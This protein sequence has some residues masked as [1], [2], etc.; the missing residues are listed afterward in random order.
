MIN[1]IYFDALDDEGVSDLFVYKGDMPADDFCRMQKQLSSK[2]EHRIRT[3]IFAAIA[4]ICLLTC[5]I[6]GGGTRNDTLTVLMG[7]GGLVGFA[8]FAGLA[9]AYKQEELTN[10][11]T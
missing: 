8:V 9:G 11:Q 7:L 10:D 3:Y 2:P 6:A 4:I 5:L 1:C